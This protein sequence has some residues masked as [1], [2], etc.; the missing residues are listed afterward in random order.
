MSDNELLSLV[1]QAEQD[2]VIFNGEFMRLNESYLSTYLGN[3]YGDEQA[4]Q[5]QVIS[6]DVQD[7]V[8]SDMPSLVRIF[9]N[10]TNIMQF[11]PNSKRQIDIQEAEEKTAYINWIINH[12][13]NSYKIKVDWIKDSEIQK[14]GVVRYDY[15]EKEEVEEQEYQGLSQ[16][17]LVQLVTDLQQESDQ[18]GSTVDILEQDEQDGE[19]S[20]KFRVKRKNNSFVIKNIPTENFLISR[21]AKSKDEAELVGDRTLVTR[22]HLISMGYD[23]KIV[24]SLPTASRSQGDTGARGDR[25]GRTRAGTLPQIRYQDQGGDASGEEINHWASQ[26]VELSNLYVNVDYDDDG[27]AEK[28]HILKSG[29]VIL[30]NEPF[31][32]APY[33]MFS[34][35]T[36]PH[37][38]IGR[39]RAEMTQQTQRVKTVLF[40]QMLDNAYRVNNG[41]VVVNDDDTNIDDLLTVRPNGIVRTSGDPRMAVAQLE[42][43]SIS[44]NVLQIIQYVDSTRAQSTGTYLDNQGL[45]GDQL[46]NETATRFL[47]I[48][49]QGEAKI[50][51][52]ARNLAETGFRELYTGLAWMVQRF[53]DTPKEILVLGK[54]L[55][56]DPRKW[57]FKHELASNVGLA[58]GDDENTV[59][60]MT[61][62]LQ[63][64]QQL[65]SMG[66][67]LT[68][69]KKTYNKLSTMLKAMGINK[70]SDYY[71]DPEIPEETLMAQNEQLLALA[72]QQK[73]QLEASNPLAEAEQVKAQ[74]SLLNTQIKEQGVDNKNKIE[75]AKLAEEQRQFD[76]NT[77]EEQKSQIAQLEKDYVELE[78]QFKTDIAGQGQ[79]G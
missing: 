67:T 21:N 32:L 54:E 16:I 9:G 46:Y 58:A 11:E 56:V 26:E 48:Q 22:S 63:I 24:R 49:E 69:E 71:N 33:A 7:V 10:N 66:S 59:A 31:P 45:D 64:D 14:L 51:L 79:G 15:E 53:Q 62:L 39:S 70:V 19:F 50:E 29:N 57:R 40:R 43:P 3:P 25:F 28:R 61:G 37:D 35:V 2:A 60:N 18:E 42:T 27:I 68:D 78:L 23:E 65:K 52:I 1:G 20:I 73:Q 77:I 12:Q 5:S 44:Q 34:S 4:D 75:V 41:R 72:E 13:K 38:A 30:E 76:I 8:E 74:A 36:M 17:E 6:T 47:G 55:T